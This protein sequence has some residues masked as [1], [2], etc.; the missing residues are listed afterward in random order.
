[1]EEVISKEVVKDDK[2]KSYYEIDARIVLEK[3]FM[4]KAKSKE[5]AMAQVREL[6]REEMYRIKVSNLERT[7]YYYNENDTD[8]FIVDKFLDDMTEGEE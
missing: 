2:K 5:E 4:I 8:I 1:M 3:S 7:S 6:I